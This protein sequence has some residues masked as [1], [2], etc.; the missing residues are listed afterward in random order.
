[1]L[2]HDDRRHHTS[3]PLPARL[4]ADLEPPL[5][6]ANYYFFWCLLNIHQQ[7]GLDRVFNTILTI[8]R[9]SSLQGH[10]EVKEVALW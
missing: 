6:P 9:F 5:S 3:L 1:M 7:S 10:R 8:D 2:G 4:H